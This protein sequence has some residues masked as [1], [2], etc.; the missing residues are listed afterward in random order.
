MWYPLNEGGYNDTRCIE[1][2]IAKTL[3][4][5]AIGVLTKEGEGAGWSSNTKNCLFG[6]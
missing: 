6:G 2:S 3:H 1:I 5:V 4:P